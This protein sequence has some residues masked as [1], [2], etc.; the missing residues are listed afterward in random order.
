MARAP[1]PRSPGGPPSPTC[2]CPGSRARSGRGRAGRPSTARGASGR[3]G[4]RRPGRHA[5][6]PGTAIPSGSGA[7][8]SSSSIS[9]PITA[10]SPAASAA[11]ANRTAPYSPWWSVIASPVKPQL[12]RPCDEVVRGRCPVQEREVAVAVQLGV[13]GVCHGISGGG[14][15]ILEHLFDIDQRHFHPSPL[16][17]RSGGR[18]HHVRQRRHHVVRAGRPQHGLHAR[19]VRHGDHDHARRHGRLH[20]HR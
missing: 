7:A 14:S 20:A 2:R 16:R 6:R 19:P 11:L 9:I 1:P 5:R 3:T 10:C 13:R 15:G 18:D 8:A 17:S 12:H 4:D